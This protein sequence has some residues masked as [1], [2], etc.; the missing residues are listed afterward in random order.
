VNQTDFD[1]LLRFA[2]GLNDGTTPGACPDLGEVSVA[3]A[4]VFPWGDDNCDSAVDA[5]DALYVLY[6]LAHEARVELHQPHGC[7]SIGHAIA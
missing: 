4:A 7:T 2:A 3:L 5:V 1:F 6:V